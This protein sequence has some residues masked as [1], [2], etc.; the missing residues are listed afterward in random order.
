MPL[1]QRITLE[2]VYSS[3]QQRNILRRLRPILLPWNAAT[4]NQFSPMIFNGPQK[5]T[6]FAGEADITPTLQ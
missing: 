6:I 4:M 5:L 2:M 1:T 3:Q